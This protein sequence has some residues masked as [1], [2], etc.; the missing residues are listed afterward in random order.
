MQKSLFRRVLLASVCCAATATPVWAQEAQETVDENVIVVTAQ[1]RA[2][3]V[4]DVPIAIDVVGAEELRNS[5]FSNM[6]DISKIAPVVQLNQDQGTVKVTMRGVG[7][8]SN[9]EAQDTS[10]VVSIDGEYM[11]R[12]HALG[13][14]LFDIERVEVL[15]GP[16]G[17]LYGRNSTGGAINFITRKPGSDFGANASASYG[18]YNAVRVDAGVDLPLGEVAAVRVAGFY[19]ERDGYVTRTMAVASRFVSRPAM[20]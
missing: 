18:N 14:A 3:D 11:N 2:Q 20:H 9:D 8:N 16:Q 17:T 1:N 10:V 6:N 4:N 19:D 13:S 5:G 12:P 7:T 15:R